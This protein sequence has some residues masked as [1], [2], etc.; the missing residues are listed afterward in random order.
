MKC[1]VPAGDLPGYFG[2]NRKLHCAFSWTDRKCSQKRRITRSSPNVSLC[3]DD[4]EGLV[5]LV[6]RGRLFEKPSKILIAIARGFPF[7]R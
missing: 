2:P 7:E 5:V 6:N 3:E 1:Q 4:V